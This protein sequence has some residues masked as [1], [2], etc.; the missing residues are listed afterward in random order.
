VLTIFSRHVEAGFV[1]YVGHTQG[2]E[3]AGFGRRHP[4]CNWPLQPGRP[5]ESYALTFANEESVVREEIPS[6]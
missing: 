5:K 1:G 6:C 2:E 4:A 3:T